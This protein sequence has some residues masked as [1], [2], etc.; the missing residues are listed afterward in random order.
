[1]SKERKIC[2]MGTMT[3]NLNHLNVHSPTYVHPQVNS[4]K[5]NS[6]YY[7]YFEINFFVVHQEQNQLLPS[8][9][10]DEYVHLHQSLDLMQCFIYGCKHFTQSWLCES[11]SN[12]SGKFSFC[13]E[14]PKTSSPSKCKICEI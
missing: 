6:H 4:L 5:Q 8:M 7:K 3:Q 10:I 9:V 12:P 2:K 14:D 1:V 11:P 13:L